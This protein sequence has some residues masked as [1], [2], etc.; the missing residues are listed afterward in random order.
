GLVVADCT[1]WRDFRRDGEPV[2]DSVAVVAEIRPGRLP[3]FRKLASVPAAHAEDGTTRCIVTAKVAPGTI[4]VLLAEG[5]PVA[6]LELQAPYLPRRPRP[7]PSGAVAPR[8]EDPPQSASPVLVGVIDQGCPFAHADLR[9]PGGGTRILSLWLQDEHH[10]DATRRICTVPAQFGRG[11]QL[12]RQRLD[13]LMRRFTDQD[14]RIDEAA[15]HEAA[16]LPELRRSMLHGAGVL[17]LVAGARPAMTRMEPPRGS[18]SLPVWTPP[19]PLQAID[20]EASRSDIVFVQ[21]P[22]DALQDSSSGSL[23][24]YVL[25]GLAYI[26]SCA[27]PQTRRIVVN[28]SDGSSHGPHDGTWMVT[29]A[30]EAMVEAER[31][32]G[33]ELRIVIAAGNS[34]DEERHAQ[35]DYLQPGRAAGVTLRVQPGSEMPTQVVIRIPAGAAG[36]EMRIATPHH[37]GDPARL[38]I[39]R[40]GEAVCW[41]SVGAAECVAVFPRRAPGAASIEA[42]VSWAPTERQDPSM[43]RSMAGD[44][45]IEF[46]SEAGCAEPIHLYVPRSQRNPGAL[47]RGRQ[48]VFVD[49][50]TG[51]D[52]DPRRW[53]RSLKEDPEPALSPTRRRGS[54]TALA[55]GAAGMGIEVVGANYRRDGSQSCY[56]SRGPTV[57]LPNAQPSRAAPNCLRPAD[58]SR[59]LRGITVA[60]ATGGQVVRVTGSSFAAPQRAREIINAPIRSPS[61]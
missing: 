41:P 40:E 45:R 36:I 25:D 13:E 8:G 16:G 5:G 17:S 12:T 1:A 31:K 32:R 47:H 18:G 49:V 38:G 61:A 42:L 50:S 39:V 44:W 35:L 52:Y 23:G 6:R 37:A 30:M 55:T 2:P 20:D 14:G 43:P 19:Q 11:L 15:C 54:H 9:A 59:A 21:P 33:R 24:R 29:S 3:E 27:G 56:S 60:G 26:L 28:I 34:A 58:T 48:A 57:S 7:L 10:A 53:L 22:R 46:A 4:G 51:A